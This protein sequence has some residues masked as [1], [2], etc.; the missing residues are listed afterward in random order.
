MILVGP[1]NIAWERLF[2]GKGRMSRRLFDI[3]GCVLTK[4]ESYSKD[5]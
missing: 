2:C 5:E 3:G 4:R 1:E